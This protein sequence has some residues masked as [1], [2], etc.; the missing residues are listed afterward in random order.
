MSIDRKGFPW[1]MV[2][3]DMRNRLEMLSAERSLH[4][5]KFGRVYPA[6]LVNHVS[7]VS[8]WKEALKW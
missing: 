7:R 2:P 1:S 5:E 6:S 3:D 4:A 8:V